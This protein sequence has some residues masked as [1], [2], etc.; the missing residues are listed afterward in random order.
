MVR[1]L[2]DGQPVHHL[3][4]VK[5]GGF[6]VLLLTD[7]VGWCLSFF[8]FVVLIGQ[9]LFAE[10]VLVL[11]LHGF[12]ESR[13]VGESIVSALPWEQLTPSELISCGPLCT[14]SFGAGC[15]KPSRCDRAWCVDAH[16]EDDR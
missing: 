13:P 9:D 10:E 11:C 1:T 14:R 8:F 16:T 5:V 7:F 3:L 6:L 15:S 4:R 2:R 12:F